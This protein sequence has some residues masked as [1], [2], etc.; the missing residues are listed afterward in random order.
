MECCNLYLL[1]SKIHVQTC[2]R[3]GDAQVFPCEIPSHRIVLHAGQNEQ[4]M[5]V[6]VM[7]SILKYFIFI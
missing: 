6:P 3:R 2:V 4:R 5:L 1:D 7:R